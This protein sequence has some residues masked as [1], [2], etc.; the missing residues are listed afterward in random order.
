MVRFK[1][2]YILFEACPQKSSQNIEINEKEISEVLT[3]F[4]SPPKIT[5][6]SASKGLFT[7]ISEISGF[8]KHNTLCKSSITTRRLE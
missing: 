8:R 2:R 1:N 6:L 4:L 7:R 5:F 3:S